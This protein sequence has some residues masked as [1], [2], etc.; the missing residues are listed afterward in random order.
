MRSSRFWVR[1]VL[2]GLAA[3][4]V[5]A[6][7]AF[8]G[9]GGL[10]SEIQA[11]KALLGMTDDVFVRFTLHNE[12]SEDLY[13][14]SWQTALRGIHEDIFDVRRDGKPVPYIGRLYKWATPQAE[15]FIRIPAGGSVAGRV[16]LSAAYDISRTGEYSIQYR[17]PV[18][19]ALRAIGAE[20]AA[21]KLGNIESN[22]LTL[23]IERDERL[24]AERSAEAPEIAVGKA[25]SPGFVSCSSTRQSTLVTAVSNAEAI[26]LLARNYLNNLPVASRA[27]DTAYRTWFGAYLAS[28]YSTVQSHFNAIYSAFNTKTFTFHCDCTD[29][30]YAYVYSNQPYNVHLCNAFWNAPNLGIDSKAGTLVHEASHF[31]VV[32]GTSDYAYG[33]SA[34]QRLATSN[35]KKAINN[36]DSHEYFAETR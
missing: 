2:A 25:L 27:T 13:V 21:T 5:C 6:P 11:D 31:N 12:S 3:L 28:R 1:F 8:A 16:E 18:R 7:A 15:D 34:C 26:S 4:L 33:T 17:V 9:T 22:V 32:A 30:A 10:R 20:V 14:L 24:I 29:S 19:E 35:P 36:A 23:G